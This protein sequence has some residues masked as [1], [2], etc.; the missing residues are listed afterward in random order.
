MP[1]SA[2][3]RSPRSSRHGLRAAQGPFSSL[4]P[5]R[6]ARPAT[7]SPSRRSLLQTGSRSRLPRITI[8]AS[9]DFR[10]E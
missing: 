4:K 10:R 9:E 7:S 6:S 5:L 2:R 1:C 3:S 8:S